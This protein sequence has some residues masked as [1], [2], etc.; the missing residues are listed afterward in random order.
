MESEVGGRRGDGRGRRWKR[1]EMEEEGDGRERRGGH[2]MTTMSRERIKSWNSR[3]APN[4]VI[5]IL[6]NPVDSYDSNGA[7]TILI[8]ALGDEKWNLLLSCLPIF[9]RNPLKV[10]GHII[11]RWKEIF[12]ENAAPLES[13]ETVEN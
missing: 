11:R 10:L 4:I 8:S 6:K 2:T 9:P 1:K 12:K 5:H 13:R 3:S 7:I